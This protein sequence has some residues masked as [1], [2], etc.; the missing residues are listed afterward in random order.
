MQL[1]I[2]KKLWAYQTVMFRGQ[3]FCLTR[4]G[5]GLN[6]APT[7]MKAVLEKFYRKTKRSGKEHHHTLMI[8]L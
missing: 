4:L 5:F 8:F 3:R 1:K 2:D 6:V 7:I